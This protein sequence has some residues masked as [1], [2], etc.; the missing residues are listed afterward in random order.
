VRPPLVAYFPGQ[1]AAVLCLAL[2]SRACYSIYSILYDCL[3]VDIQ[4]APW[5]E[6]F[7]ADE[8]PSRQQLGLQA[9]S[10][11]PFWPRKKAAL[12]P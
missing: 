11:R 7:V 6:D 5:L 10:C 4:L 12:L 1:P 2:A 9:L 3:V 8:D